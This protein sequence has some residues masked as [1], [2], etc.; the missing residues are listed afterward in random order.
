[1]K[2][3][4]VVNI[5]LI[6]IIVIGISS[7]LKLR[8]EIFPPTDIDT[9]IVNVKYPGASA[10]DAEINAVIPIE[11]KIKEIAGI[12]DY[13]SLSVDNG[14]IIYIYI[15]Q[16]IVD[17]QKVKDDIY[18]NLSYISDI[19]PDVEE[20]TVVDANPKMMA[21]YQ[22]G[23]SINDKEKTNDA[24]LK[25]FYEFS[26]GFEKKLL[27]IKGVNEIRVSGY[28]DREIKIAINSNKMK[29]YF[30]SLND[31]IK[32][33]QNRNVRSTGG[34]LQS[35]QKE[36][37][38]V[39]IGQFENPFDVKNVIVRSSYEGKRILIKDLALVKDS[40][41][42]PDILVRV[43]KQP[44]II[45]SIVKNENADVV[46]TVKNIK[47]FLKKYKK[48]MSKDFKLTTIEDRSL[49]I[50]ALLD[51]V[52]SNALIGFI[53]IFVVLLL[54]LNFRSAFWTAL[55][56]P[57]TILILMVFMKISD[58][59]LNLISLGAVITV[60]GMLVDHGIVISENIFTF[61]NKG[62]S[63]VDAAILGTKEVISPIIVTVLTT[64]VGFL[65][66]LYVT[67][68]MGKFISVYPIIIAAALIASFLEAVLFLPNHLAHGKQRPI[69]E[70]DWFTP[71]T[72]GYKKF[73]KFVL[74]FRYLILLIFI[75]IFIGTLMISK[76]TIRN[77]TLFWD[78]TSDAFYINLEA[79]PGTSL[80]KNSE[81]TKKIENLVFKKIKKDE[82]LSMKT[83]IGHHTVKRINSKGNHENW[84]QITVYLVPK[85]ERKRSVGQIIRSLKKDLNPKK[86][87]YFEKI[88]FGK[89]V[90]GP[91][92]GAAIDLR[93]IGGAAKTRKTLQN[94]IEKFLKKIKGVVEIDNDQ[95][96]GKEE[97][98]ITFNY[99]KMA[100]YGI[101]VVAVAQTVR[102]A[103]EGVIATYI[104]TLDKHLDFRVEISENFKRDEK[105][106][107]NLL[108]PNNQG[109]LIRLDEIANL[110]SRK[111]KSMI[112]HYNGDR[113]IS[114]IAKVDKKITTPNMVVKK[115][116]NSFKLPNKKYPDVFLKFKGEAA[117]SKTAMN[118]LIIAFILSLIAIYLIL[119]FLFQTVEQPFIILLTVPFGLIGVLLAFKLHN[120]PLSF[121]GIVGIIGLSGVVVNDSVI[122]VDFIN[123]LIKNNSDT[124]NKNT[125]INMIIE[126]AQK[127]L[128]PII[129]TTITTV[130]ALIPTVYGIG[131]DVSSLKPTVMALGYGILFATTLTL[132]LIPSLYV[133]SIDIKAIPG[134]LKMMFKG[135]NKK[136]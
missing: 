61:K 27:K 132:I 96:E 35:V 12:K 7:I 118:D 124:N 131:G 34:S 82:F 86:I 107:L 116:R 79:N 40:F 63:P 64:I 21:V 58:I 36:K 80:N 54:F 37:N 78:N 88:F 18:R 3:K 73:L 71:F 19:S 130:A 68:I 84:S 30:I 33:I 123:R 128:R 134:K 45:F 113:V 23:L 31:V 53:L 1:A 24:I 50:I 5:L 121:M 49:S 106:L 99:D 89:Q 67:G 114:I 76:D 111:S 72:K 25:K 85:T 120:M 74:K 32:S 57:I 69:K 52:K 66:L 38:I 94:E 43:N 65:P 100:Q 125:L 14:A 91:S 77:F 133:I 104:Q 98:L 119:V 122:M 81:L 115:I 90:I 110:R 103:Y 60:L 44:G 41:K 28:R 48:I 97:L 10:F 135:K 136:R 83:I 9:M 29:K 112:N 87:K 26:D 8:Q 117:E 47:S 105:F 2:N 20:I 127:R 22:L 13:T 93:I 109:R 70:T 56:V 55:G 39:T 46:K 51:V 62:F 17:K 102:A 6:L 4:L 42:D 108:I 126:G 59:S 15:D 101:T 92:P 11:D 75:L 16:D 95:K 129:L